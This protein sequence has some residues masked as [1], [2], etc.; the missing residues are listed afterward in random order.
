MIDKIIEL[1]WLL[2]GIGLFI[3]FW[4]LIELSIER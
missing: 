3:L 2:L 1:L 4:Y